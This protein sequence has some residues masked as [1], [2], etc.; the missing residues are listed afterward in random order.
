[1][2]KQTLKN[3]SSLYSKQSKHLKTRIK[4]MFDSGVFK[5][6][7]DRLNAVFQSFK[8]F[9]MNMGKPTMK[10]RYVYD[11][12]P[13][14]SEDINLTMQEVKHD[15][16]VAFEE[17][18][19]I[20]EGATLN[21]DYTVT[22]RK[23]LQN[24]V[25]RIGE[26]LN[27]YV[28]SAKNTISRNIT[29]Q[30]S[31]INLDKIDFSHIPGEKAKVHTDQGVVTLRVG[32]ARNNVKTDTGVATIVR[33]SDKN[34]E[35]N[36]WPSNFGVV[37][38]RGGT[39]QSMLDNVQGKED[40][41]EN[42]ELL[43]AIDPRDDPNVIF[44][45]NPNTW[46]EYQMINFP[47]HYKDNPC[48]GYGLHF[49]DGSPIYYGNEKTDKLRMALTIK[50]PDEE[51][52]DINWIQITPHFF[53]D[54]NGETAKKYGFII[55]DI[56]LSTTGAGEGSFKSVLTE[57]QKNNLIFSDT[58]VSL[59]EPDGGRGKFKGT[60]LYS[61]PARKAKYIRIEMR[62]DKPYNC[63]VGHIWW[64]KT[65]TETSQAR[66]LI[67]F[68]GKE[69]VEDKNE[70]IEGPAVS[71]EMVAYRSTLTDIQEIGGAF[72]VI[73]ETIATVIGTVVSIFYNKE[74]TISNVEHTPYIEVFPGWRWSIG[75]RNLYVM[76]NT[77]AEVGSVCSI[78]YQTPKP[79][80]T[81]S[82]SVSESIPEEFFDGKDGN[83]GLDKKHE[84]IKYY[85]SF[86]KGRTWHRMSPLE[87]NPAPGVE[88]PG[89]TIILNSPL[90]PDNRDPNSV[91]VD[92]EIE[93][94]VMLRADFSRPSGKKYETMT[95]VLYDYTLR[96]A[97]K[98]VAE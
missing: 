61:F 31:F 26:M 24:R 22:E 30:D 1:M 70:R 41:K 40:E 38:K 11:L 80:G 47:E 85:L 17:T 16:D 6:E 28:V 56:K 33:Q 77:Y 29:V 84:W 94:S 19:M 3:P 42:Y 8:D 36:G 27:D 63:D 71:K 90:A 18:H 92:S 34:I 88:I 73:G 20:G 57:D 10:K 12:S 15:I 51:P 75:I 23:R 89:K 37:I 95:P 91:Y 67:F 35:G 93:N 39:T 82:L 25:Q 43:W 86:D 54:V 53:A 5:T 9:F 65:W 98:E 64:E 21:F 62:T 60:A 59:E 66:Y 83:P 45:E 32:G 87:H 97:P 78:N 96:I 44:D 13:P 79:I 74:T 55:E 7:S 72:G 50:L 81:V 68:K 48:L 52:V 76:T 58:K 49:D 14:R 69:K 2:N 46:F 4:E